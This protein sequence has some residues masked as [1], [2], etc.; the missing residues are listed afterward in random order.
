[1]IEFPNVLLA[2]EVCDLLRI[3]PST[4]RRLMQK[5][6]LRYVKIGGSIRYIEED[7]LDLLEQTGH[8]WLNCKCLGACECPDP[9]I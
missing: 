2:G 8:R 6:T 9:V 7:V 4:L 3:S 1:M 5:K